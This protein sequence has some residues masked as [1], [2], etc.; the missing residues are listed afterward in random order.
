MQT[1]ATE[2]GLPIGYSDHTDGTLVSVAAVAMGSRIIEKHFTLDR[3]LPGPD[4]QASLEPE[5]LEIMIQQIRRIETCLGDGKKSPRDSELPVR[6]L[7]RRSVTLATDK[8]AGDVIQADD[9]VL[10]RPGTGIPPKQLQEVIGR[11]IRSFQ[12]AGAVLGWQ[13][14][15]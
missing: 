3:N 13:D 15:I 4:H 7:V 12:K 8:A 10:L 9:L 1:M 6:D 2:F 14:L 5:E 11:R